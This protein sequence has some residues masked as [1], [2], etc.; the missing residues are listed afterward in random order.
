MTFRSSHLVGAM[1]YSLDS[2]TYFPNINICLWIVTRDRWGTNQNSYE[3][4]LKK[5]YSLCRPTTKELI[6]M[7]YIIDQGSYHYTGS[8]HQ[9]KY[10]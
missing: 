5:K 1:K 3:S 6:W 9:T 4:Y 7:T 2:S 10:F 8:T